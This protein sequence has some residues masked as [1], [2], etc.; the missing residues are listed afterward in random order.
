MRL[1]PQASARMSEKAVRLSS[2]RGVSPACERRPAL[3]YRR[4]EGVEDAR[5][6]VCGKV[7]GDLAFDQQPQLED[8]ADVRRRG[9]EHAC[10]A[11]RLDLDEAVALKADQ[12]LAN[13]CLRDSEVS[14][15]PG[16]DELLA[17]S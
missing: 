2:T 10:S 15:D 5:R 11:I 13:G 12:R 6:T 14:G 7:A 4:L 16:L 3:G 1:F 17:G 9:L 8:L